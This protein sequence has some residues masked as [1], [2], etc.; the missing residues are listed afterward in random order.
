M[1]TA[2]PESSIMTSCGSAEPCCWLVTTLMTGFQLSKLVYLCGPGPW[3][4]PVWKQAA[5][6]DGRAS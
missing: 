6:E 3:A 2:L 4:V 1:V 5:G